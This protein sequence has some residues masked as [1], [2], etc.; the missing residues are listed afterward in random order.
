MCQTISGQEQL[1]DAVL[2]AGVNIRE[3]S[4][5]ETYKYLGLFEAEGLDCGGSKKMILQAYLKRLSL[6]WK[7]YL[8]GPRKVRTNNSFC[9]PLLSY[10]FG[11]IPW[12]KKE[13]TQ[14]DVKT[15]KLLT[16]AYSHHPW[17]T[18]ECIYLP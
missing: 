3:L 14:F 4:V 7:S 15:R 5:G 16:A 6:I 12:T 17:S 18:V 13:M 8:S 9:V 10:G 11:L 2:P 1:S